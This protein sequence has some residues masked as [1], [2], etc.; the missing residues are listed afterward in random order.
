MSEFKSQLRSKSFPKGHRQP[1]KT[2]LIKPIKAD[3]CPG[4][5]CTRFATVVKQIKCGFNSICNRTFCM[6]PK[7]AS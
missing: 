2:N 1:Y 4:Q 7:H 3:K 6:V 5:E